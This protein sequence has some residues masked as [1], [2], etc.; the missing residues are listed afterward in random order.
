MT[1]L[2]ASG[3]APVNGL[4][5]YYELYGPDTGTPLLLLHG[6]LFNI[7]LQFGPL[8]PGLSEGR[9][10]IATDFQGHGRTN[11]A[12]RPL[13]TAG[14]TADVVGLLAH[15]GVEQVD[16]FGYSIGG[17]VAL[18]LAVEHPELVRRAIISSVAFDPSGDRGSENAE[19]VVEMSVDMI[20]GTPMEADYRAKSPHPDRLQTLLDKL[21]T[22]GKLVEATVRNSANPTM[23]DA[24][25][26][27]NVIPGEAVAH[28]DGRF[29]SGAE[30]EF[31]A[32]ADVFGTAFWLAL[33]GVYI[34]WLA[35]R[36]EVFEP[37]TK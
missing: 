3:Y 5:M 22:A 4:E 33:N 19:A 9:R 6:G 34:W 14:L 8:L 10:V 15:L 1:T 26:K 23:L 12:D 16:V 11:D 18:N 21:G 17:A 2:A 24:G 7:D 30:D 37:R 32:S 20:A 31:R 35:T 13:S 29:L 36:R 27:V 25:Y 28:V